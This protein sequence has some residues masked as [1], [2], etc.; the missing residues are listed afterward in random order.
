MKEPSK[1]II[2]ELV[3]ITVEETLNKMLYAGRRM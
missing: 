2:G 1:I 3:C